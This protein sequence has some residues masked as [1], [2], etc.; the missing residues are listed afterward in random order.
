M[1]TKICKTNEV[2]DF[3]SKTLKNTKEV[4]D[5]VHIPLSIL[6]VQRSNYHSDE[7]SLVNRWGRVGSGAR[8]TENFENTIPVVPLS[9]QILVIVVND[10]IVVI[11]MLVYLICLSINQYADTIMIQQIPNLKL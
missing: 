1:I 9:R 2:K 11:K 6:K 4:S 7:S 3:V 8:T 10:M 5:F